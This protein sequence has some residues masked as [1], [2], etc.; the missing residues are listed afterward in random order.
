M[1]VLDNFL[2]VKILVVGDI[3][4]DKY[5]F[6]DINKISPEAPIPILNFQ[7][8]EMRLGGA[9]N[10]AANIV[11]LGGNAML[12]GCVGDDS[13][14]KK[15]EKELNQV[16]ITNKLIFLKNQITIIKQRIIS[17]RQ[18]IVRIDFD[19]GYKDVSDTNFFQLISENINN[20]DLIILSDYGKG[21]LSS[22]KKI[23]SLAK[24]MGKK[25]IIDPKGNDFSKYEN[26]SILTPNFSEFINIVGFCNSEEEI[27]S[28]AKTLCNK[29]KLGYLLLT[30]GA[31]GMT[32]ISNNETPLHLDA[33]TRD[34]FDVTG[35]GDTVLATLASCISSG[36]AIKEALYFS[37]KAASLVVS[38]FG[39][40]TIFL[41][42]LKKVFANKYIYRNKL[43]R[44]N[45]L[46]KEIKLLKKSGKTIIMTNGCFDILHMG[47]IRYLKEAKELGDILIVAL[48]SDIS[49]KNIKGI[50]RPI[51]N[52]IP[53]LEV[54]AALEFVDIITLFNENTPIEVIKVIKPNILVKAGDYK[55]NEIVGSDIVKKYNGQIKL[56]TYYEGYSTSNAIQKI[57]GNRK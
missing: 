32:L 30:R 26:A 34:V 45:D 50:K 56:L 52:E 24:S 33:F 2:N 14:G 40:S 49:I 54:L 57:T 39:T 12:I 18:H 10:V 8:E 27:I 1:N 51:N 15:V 31:K 48:N 19:N 22:I 29:L 17:Q 35:A 41:E 55:L 13:Q 6:G 42:D 16:G 20:Y 23:I 3:I 5:W 47:H 4:Y 9:A 36:F 7:R 11:A 53:R 44:R 43:L 38:K 46:K 25:I 37:N 21:T 28:K